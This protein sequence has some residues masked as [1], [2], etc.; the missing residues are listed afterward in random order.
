MNTPHHKQYAVWLLSVAMLC[1]LG[2]GCGTDTLG[3]DEPDRGVDLADEPDAVE[4]VSEDIGNDPDLQ[5][6]SDAHL[7]DALDSHEDSLDSDAATDN[8]VPSDTAPDAA[9]STD[10]TDTDPDAADSAD[11]T[12]VVDVV[13]ITPPPG[14]GVVLSFDD[15]FVENWFEYRDLFLDNGVKATFFVTRPDE[16]SEEAVLQLQILEADGH[17][18]ACHGLTHVSP[19]EYAE[20]HSVA[21]YVRDEVVPALET[22]RG[23]G[24]DPQTF[25]YPWGG[26]SNELDAALSNVFS[27]LRAS[28]TIDDSRSQY[29]WD[30]SNPIHGARIDTGTATI[31]EVTAAMDDVLLSGG[32]LVLYA[33]RILDSSE[34]SHVTPDLLEAVIQAAVDRELPFYRFQDLVHETSSAGPEV[35]YNFLD[36]GY[37]DYADLMLEDTWYTA[38]RYDEIY[39]GWPLTWTEDPLDEKYW[40]FIFYSLRPTRHLLYAYRVT[41]DTRYRDKLIDVLYS[42]ADSGASSPFIDDKHTAAFLTMVLVN[43]Y[44][45]LQRTGDLPGDLAASLE[46]I[47]RDRGAFLE[48]SAHFELHNNHGV[49]QAA[50]LMLIAANFPDFEESPTWRDLAADRLTLVVDKNVADDGVQVEQSPFYHFY[51]LNFFWQLHDWNQAWDIWDDPAFAAAVDG[52]VDFATYVTQPDGHLPLIGSTDDY[53]MRAKFPEIYRAIGDVRPDFRYVYTAGALGEPPDPTNRLF[54]TSG[55][56]ILRSGFGE[57]RDPIEEAQVIFDVGPYRTGHS[58]LDALSVVAFADGH[59]L[60]VDSGLFTYEAGDQ[61]DYYWST[62]AHNTVVVDGLE[63]II[64]SAFAGTHQTGEG[65]A[66]QSGYHDLY[67]SVRHARG[68]LLIENLGM[69]VIDELQGEGDA[70]HE[71]EQLWHFPPGVVVTPTDSAATI[72]NAEEASFAHVQQALGVDEVITYNGSLDPL[73]GWYSDDYEI[74]YS[75]PVTGFSVTGSSATFVTLVS[76]AEWASAP[77]SVHVAEPEA[78]ELTVTLSNG[79][80]LAVS[81]ALASDGEA[82]EVTAE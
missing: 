66:W 2:A 63:Q 8:D 25:S 70:E 16:L 45:K 77:P 33:H 19:K 32:A 80:S 29:L 44:V 79:F 82:V 73:Q 57:T 22:L 51:V 81:G 40:R 41:G 26:R 13:E 36:E 48:D 24:F 23:Y 61:H 67:D 68:V 52:M 69:L 46:A 56:A 17:E 3:T 9:H 34:F 14:P 10:A 75:A 37:L 1:S 53:D 4:D 27:L 39:L 30:G 58:H 47:I 11:A 72:T 71:F 64:G 65:W 38:N 21:A 55:W 35:V 62:R 50:A 31:E 78:G 76:F 7:A 54:E 60:L 20:E 59:R 18:I 15:D 6:D 43:T 28:G 5:D 12:D 42:F 74:E 49:T